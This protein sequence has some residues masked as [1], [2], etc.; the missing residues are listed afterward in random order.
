MY[1][2]ILCIR[3]YRCTKHDQTNSSQNTYM[4]VCV[5]I[6]WHHI[7]NIHIWKIYTTVISIKVTWPIYYVI[8]VRVIYNIRRRPIFFFFFYVVRNATG[9][10]RCNPVNRVARDNI[11]T[12]HI[13]SHNPT[14]LQTCA[15]PGL[16]T[17]EKYF[18]VCHKYGK[19][20][21]LKNDTIYYI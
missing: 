5:C 6:F 10:R 19:Y 13:P 14:Q 7:H 8:R 12:Q 16:I 4:C 18:N 9:G 11:H 15:K 20:R 3:V 21:F 17:V 1:K 2:D